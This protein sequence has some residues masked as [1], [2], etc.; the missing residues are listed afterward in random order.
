MFG[1][2]KADDALLSILKEEEEAMQADVIFKC[3]G[4][5]WRPQKSDQTGLN[6]IMC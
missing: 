2:Q 5:F 4:N 6:H 1:K 3:D